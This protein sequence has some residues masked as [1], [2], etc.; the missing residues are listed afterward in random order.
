M[1]GEPAASCPR[2]SKP[3]TPSTDQRTYDTNG[4]Q[5]GPPLGK[6]MRFHCACGREWLADSENAEAHGRFLDRSGLR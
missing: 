5:N 6:R 3:G 2:C 4:N 1:K